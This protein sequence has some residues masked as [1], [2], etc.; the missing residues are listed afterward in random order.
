MMRLRYAEPQGEKY[1]GRSKSYHR[2]PLPACLSSISI[3]Q[4]FVNWPLQDKVVRNGSRAIISQQAF[5]ALT[6]KGTEK[7]MSVIIYTEQISLEEISALNPMLTGGSCIVPVHTGHQD[8]TA[9]R[10]TGFYRTRMLEVAHGE[11][12]FWRGLSSGPAGVMLGRWIELTTLKKASCLVASE[13]K[14][15]QKGAWQP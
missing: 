7:M 3:M 11:T 13:R 14:G 1:G 8:P 4:C 15:N 6:M 12:R 9:K 5:W 2:F 10:S